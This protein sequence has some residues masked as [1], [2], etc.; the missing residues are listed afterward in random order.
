M[1]EDGRA[2]GGA[3]ASTAWIDRVAN[4]PAAFL[5]PVTMLVF[6]ILAAPAVMGD[7]ATFDEG[8][9]LSSGWT[10]LVRRDFRLSNDNPPLAKV[11]A[12]LPLV[13]LDVRWPEDPSA[14]NEGRRH[15]FDSL[16]LYH[17]GNDPD[18]LLRSARFANLFWSLLL[19]GAV[20]AAARER[21]GPRAGLVDLVLATFCPVL[22]GLGHL[23]TVDA[24]GAAL[25]FL[26]AAASPRHLGLQHR[27]LPAAHAYVSYEREWPPAPA[28]APG[29]LVAVSAS[30]FVG[31][32]QDDP[33]PYRRLLR[34]LRPVAT[35][36]RS[37]L[38]FRWEPPAAA[39]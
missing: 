12:A 39:R 6:L 26:A 11:F 9:H 14:W 30:A 13:A 17:S 29:D 33:D 10:A 16:W 2:G 32:G 35:I 23:V 24:A 19:L 25:F 1:S 20:Y 37:I 31:V 21:F 18:L 36:G 8:I 38:I 5:L 28:P 4:L 34:D 7:S 3:A 15:T 27:V 22:L